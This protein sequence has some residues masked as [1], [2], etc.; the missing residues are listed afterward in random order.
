MSHQGGFLEKVENAYLQ[1]FKLVI[2]IVLT[3][4]LIASIILAVKGWNDLNAEA[5]APSQGKAP[6]VT[7]EDFHYRATGPAGTGQTQTGSG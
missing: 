1:I 5:A 7:V 3:L 2:L 6:S 4:A